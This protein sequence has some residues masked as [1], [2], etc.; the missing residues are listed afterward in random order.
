MA[1]HDDLMKEKKV[2]AALRA[3]GEPDEEILWACR[4]KKYGADRKFYRVF[5]ALS[6]R[7]IYMFLSEHGKQYLQCK[8]FL[9]LSFVKAISVS[10]D[11]LQLALRCAPESY[12][13]VLRFTKKN[14]SGKQACGVLVEE[15]QRMLEDMLEENVE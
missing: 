5:V 8:D 14:A 3:L 15:V 9:Q 4:A 13:K 1:L 11:S 10:R 7:A 2:L 6:H 12:N